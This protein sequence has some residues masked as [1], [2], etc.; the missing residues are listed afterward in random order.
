MCSCYSFA[1]EMFD[2][3]HNN[4]RN[5]DGTHRVRKSRALALRA[6]SEE[7]ADGRTVLEPKWRTEPARGMIDY[8]VREAG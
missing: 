4:Q 3:W 2:S 5:M 7:V 6:L 1:I 8:S